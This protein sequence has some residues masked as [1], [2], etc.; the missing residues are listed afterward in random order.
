MSNADSEIK[1]FCAEKAREMAL[2]RIG[3]SELAK[4]VDL[5]EPGFREESFGWIFIV[6]KE[7]EFH[8]TAME[9]NSAIVVSRFG[10]VRVIP[11]LSENLI[12]WEEYLKKLGLY[13]ER[14]KQ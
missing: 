8:P 5:L 12:E 11:D 1:V 6:N 4:T 13:I 3:H 2:K 14:W 7:I 9:P 10:G